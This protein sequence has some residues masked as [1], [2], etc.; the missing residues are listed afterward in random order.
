MRLNEK[1][2]LQ[3]EHRVF[4]KFIS[5]YLDLRNNAREYDTPLI[6]LRLNPR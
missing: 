5:D 4:H 2:N 3:S 6:S 1:E